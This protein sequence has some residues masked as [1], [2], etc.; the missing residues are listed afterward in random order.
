[1]DSIQNGRSPDNDGD[2]NSDTQIRPQGAG[3]PNQENLAF[4]TI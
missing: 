4:S 2:N 1:M 3:R